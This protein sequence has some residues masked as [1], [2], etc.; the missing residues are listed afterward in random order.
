MP[1]W[2]VK[3]S[4][5]SQIKPLPTSDLRL[6]GSLKTQIWLQN[7]SGGSI[8]WQLRAQIRVLEYYQL[9]RYAKEGFKVRCAILL[10]GACTA[11]I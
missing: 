6:V 11:Q 3:L 4:P 10:S 1:E 8:E 2:S 9:T 7:N 5:W